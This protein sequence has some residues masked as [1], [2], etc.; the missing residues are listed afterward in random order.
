MVLPSNTHTSLPL[1][2]QECFD[3]EEQ[4]MVN[5]KFS[6]PSLKLVSC[7]FNDFVLF[8]FEQLQSEYLKCDFFL[9]N[10]CYLQHLK[11]Q[12]VFLQHRQYVGFFFFSI[13]LRRKLTTKLER[14][15]TASTYE[16]VLCLKQRDRR[17]LVILEYCLH[18]IIYLFLLHL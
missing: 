6:M 12:M 17:L 11:T 9:F 18:P 7:R 14:K 16:S 5:F 15:M 8:T 10:I 4:N 3:L 2:P 13:C 1:S